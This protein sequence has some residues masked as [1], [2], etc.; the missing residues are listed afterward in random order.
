[1][2]RAKFAVELMEPVSGSMRQRQIA[3]EREADDEEE[4]MEDWKEEQRVR[5]QRAKSLTKKEDIKQKSRLL[6]T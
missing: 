2:S 5:V 4:E 1:M 6:R 3:Q